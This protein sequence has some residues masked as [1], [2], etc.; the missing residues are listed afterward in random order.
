MANDDDLRHCL[1]T[2]RQFLAR[3]PAFGIVE[4]YERS[5][6][7]INRELGHFS[8]SFPHLLVHR[9]NGMHPE[10]MTVDDIREMMRAEIGLELYSEI[11]DR[12]G[13]DLALYDFA[14]TRFR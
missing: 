3:L 12:N 5:I 4:E 7:L 2:S 10:D 11:V 1:D 8:P 13:Y 14:R 6:A 9:V